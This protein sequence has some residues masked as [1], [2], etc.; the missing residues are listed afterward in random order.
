MGKSRSERPVGWRERRERACV[1]L[2][3]RHYRRAGVRERDEALFAVLERYLRES[4]VLLDAGCG[5]RG[6]WLAAYAARVAKAVG[7]DVVVE[8]G[9]LR[10]GVGLC[11]ADLARLPFPDASFDLVMSRSVLE[12]LDAPSAVFQELSRVTRRGG[13]L[14]MTT[15]TKWD[16]G[17][18]A[19][20]LTSTSFHR[21]FLRFIGGYGADYENY[22]TR[23]QANTRHAPIGFA[24]AAGLQVVSIEG[25]SHP[26]YYLRFSAVLYGLGIAYERFISRMGWEEL[27]GSWLLTLRKP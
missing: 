8:G 5:V 23:F 10:P 17:S 20:R 4:T 16:Y 3:Q 6:D 27:R 18:I 26:P 25:I 24:R 19:A 9:A 13:I 15:P 2:Y 1:R 21:R 11:R 12:H 7:V 22:P 14:V